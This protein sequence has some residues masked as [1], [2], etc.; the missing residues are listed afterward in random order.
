MVVSR[1]VVYNPAVAQIVKL[2]KESAEVSN[3]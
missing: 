1:L 3:G 2:K